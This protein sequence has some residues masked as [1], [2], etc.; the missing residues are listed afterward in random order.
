MLGDGRPAAF[1]RLEDADVR[2]ALQQLQRIPL[3]LG[4]EDQLDEHLVELFRQRL[5]D[6]SVEAE[7]AA[8]SA[9]PLF[10]CAGNANGLPEAENRA[11]AD[12]VDYARLTIARRVFDRRVSL[13]RDDASDQQTHD[14]ESFSN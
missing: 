11:V 3:V 12:A 6:R 10:Y 2:L 9:R 4:R 7:D 14:H 5:V 8:E 13:R 1:V